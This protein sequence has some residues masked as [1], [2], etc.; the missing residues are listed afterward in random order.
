MPREKMAAMGPGAARA[1]MMNAAGGVGNV[2][3]PPS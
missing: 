2:Q 1:G 3:D